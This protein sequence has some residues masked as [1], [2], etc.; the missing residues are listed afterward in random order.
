MAFAAL[1]IDLNARL[2]K[3]EDDMARV[4]SLWKR[5]GNNPR[6][7]AYVAAKA[8]HRIRGATWH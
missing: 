4:D 8:D 1:T 7:C 6:T 5:R 2:A 3:F